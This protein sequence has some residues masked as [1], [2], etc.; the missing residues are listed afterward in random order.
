MADAELE[1]YEEIENLDEVRVRNL[2]MKQDHAGRRG[3]TASTFIAFDIIATFTC[4]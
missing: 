2:R 4:S 1:E 3:L